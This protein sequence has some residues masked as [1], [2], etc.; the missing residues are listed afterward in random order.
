M[1]GARPSSAAVVLVTGATGSL[2]ADLV[3]QFVEHPDVATVVCINRA[4]SMPV[5]KRQADA[6]SS[7]GIELSPSSRAKLRAL[8]ADTIKPQLGLPPQEYKWL[9]ENGTHIVHMPGP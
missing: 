8:E 3:Q 5:N 7:R 6:F 1:A 2:G 4:S 9:S